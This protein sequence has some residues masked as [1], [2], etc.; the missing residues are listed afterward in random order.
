MSPSFCTFQAELH[1]RSLKGKEKLQRCTRVSVR[2]HLGRSTLHSGGLE[3]DFQEATFLKRAHEML[4][5]LPAVWLQLE[6]STLP[7]NAL[8]HK[9]RNLLPPPSSCLVPFSPCCYLASRADPVQLPNP[10]LGQDR[11]L[12]FRVPEPNGHA[13]WIVFCLQPFQESG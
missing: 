9:G 3:A 8:A 12:G 10:H 11:N 5:P 2:A 4:P 6:R 1:C 13:H 7:R